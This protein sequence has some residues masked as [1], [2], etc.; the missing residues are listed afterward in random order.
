VGNVTKPGIPGEIERVYRDINSMIDTLGLNARS[1]HAFIKGH[2]ELYKDGGRTRDDLE[3]ED[4][5]TLLEIDDLVVIEKELEEQLDQGRV[6][7]PEKLLEE[8]ALLRK[9]LLKSKLMPLPCRPHTHANLHPRSSRQA[10]RDQEID[11][12]TDRP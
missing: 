9:D 11:R 7:D 3:H 10:P 8:C 4:D 2:N 1:L 6:H 12:S 5:W